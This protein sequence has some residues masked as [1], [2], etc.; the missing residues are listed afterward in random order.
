M[1]N[2]AQ[3]GTGKEGSE[4]PSVQSDHRA[5]GT[6]RRLFLKGGIAASPVVLTL[7]SRPALASNNWDGKCSYAIYVSANPS[8]PL[9]CDAGKTPGY[10][11]NHQ[12]W[13]LP[14]QP[15]D[16]F[17]DSGFTHRRDP[18]PGGV[19]DNPTLLEV[20]QNRT[21]G[22][23]AKHAIA[24]LLNNAAFHYSPTQAQVLDYYNNKLY[25]SNEALKDFLDYVQTA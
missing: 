6:S 2:D 5:P 24:A 7:F 3:G 13:P 15:W 12:N 16:K 18:L 4:N 22:H 1:T 11:K 9:E 10:W 25:I 23:P 17:Y 20:L 14:Y 19:P 21:A 8:N